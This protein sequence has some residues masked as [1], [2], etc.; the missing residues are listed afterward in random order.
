[1][2]GVEPALPARVLLLSPHPDDIAWSLGGVVARL[3]GAAELSAVTFFGRTRYAPGCAAH[4][5]VV[6]SEVRAREEDEWARWAGVRVD[7]GDLPDA[8]LRGYD[9]DTEMGAEP[10]ADVVS[11]VVALLAGAVRSVR[12]DFVLAPLA[13]GGH[14]DHAAVLGA[15]TTLAGDWS[16][17]LIWYEDLPYAATEPPPST[18]HPL[19]VD[20]GPVWNT[21]ERGVG[22][23]PSQ[24]PDEVLPVL[25]S[26]AGVDGERAERLWTSSV[27]GATGFERLLSSQNT[28]AEP[29]SAVQ[30][31]HS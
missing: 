7:R 29:D 13:M 22:F 27:D 28:P 9:D 20:V 26:H 5:D 15:V 19:V 17:E 4:G 12:P 31:L 1:M 23:F 14:V 2:S 10:A 21:K 6:A 16:A 8:S 3:R 11:A 18:G 30:V 24:L 25:R